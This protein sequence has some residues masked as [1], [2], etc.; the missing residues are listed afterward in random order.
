M[1]TRYHDIEWGV[2]VRNDRRLFELLTLE[3]AQAGLSWSTILRKRAAYR[4]AF[5]RFDPRKVAAYTAADVRRLL[6]DPGIVRNRAKIEATI[7]NARA[8]LAVQREHGSFAAFLW[9]FVD[10]RPRTNAWRHREQVPAEDD[11]SR[12]LSRA[13]RAH[14]FRFVGPTICYAFMQAVGLINDHTTD[15][16]R[17][18]ELTRLGPTATTRGS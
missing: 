9:R 13:L 15:C 17:W 5:E 14:G 1:D 10:G 16:F 18:R 7:A 4:R 3:G 12:T 8:F 2:P 6:A 11:T